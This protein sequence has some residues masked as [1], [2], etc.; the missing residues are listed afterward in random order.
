MHPNQAFRFKGDEQVRRALLETMLDEIGFGMVFMQTPDGPRVA[1]VP[2]VS[3]GDGAVQFHLARGN[4]MAKYLDGA[5]VLAVINGPDGYV[6]PRWLDDPQTVPTW[7][8][9]TLELEGRVRRLGSEATVALLEDLT[10]RHEE[11]I[12][13]GE[14]WTIDKLTP[15]RL[16][17]LLAG[18]AGFELEVQAWRETLK[19]SQNKAAPDRARLAAALDAEGSPAIAA[20]MRSLA[21]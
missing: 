16:R 12:V 1:H 15:E 17:G 14:P 7:N 11:R 19:L 21:P 18:I 13:E 20:M 5:T 9:V 6:S 2:L 10:T 4:A 3:T 8:Y